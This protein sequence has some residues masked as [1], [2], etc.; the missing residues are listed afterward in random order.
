M[1]ISGLNVSLTGDDLL[2]IINEFIS[3]DGLEIE[4]IKVNEDIEFTGAFKKGVTINFIG[5]IKL[6][7]IEDGKIYG[8]ISKFKILNIGIFSIFRKMALKYAVKS[9]EDKGIHYEKGKI[10]I[11]IKKILQDVPFIDLDIDDIYIGNSIL[12]V[13]VK[14]INISIKGEL[15]KEAEVEGNKQEVIPGDRG[16]SVIEKVEDGYTIGRG[17]A[18]EKLPD[19]A[20]KVSDYIFIIP[21]LLALL[22]RLLKDKRVPVKTKLIIS[23][24][25]AYVAFPT[26]IIPDNIPFIGKVDELAVIFFALNR[27]VNDVPVHILLENWEGKTDII[28]ALK[29]II[30]YVTNF[31]GARNVEKIYSVIGE[32]TSL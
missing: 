25:V 13:G 7:K 3:I 31:T 19:K 22:Y 29:S 4:K 23:A 5:G 2:S 14:N 11:N 9:F 30:E 15:I 8:E 27:I 21:D 17:Y 6:G 1:N 12:N 28:I 18:C 24:S 16:I 10:I 20:K 32:L 26:D